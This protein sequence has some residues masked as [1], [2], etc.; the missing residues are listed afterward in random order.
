MNK[1]EDQTN[2][3]FGIWKN[4]KGGEDGSFPLLGDSWVSDICLHYIIDP[5]A[6]YVLQALWKTKVFK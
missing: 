1:P 2:T 3:N 5:I 4:S 6:A